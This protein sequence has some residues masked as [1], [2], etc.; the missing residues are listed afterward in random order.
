MT[1]PASA[2]RPV[3]RLASGGLV[4]AGLSLAVILASIPSNAQNAHGAVHF[5][6]TTASLEPDVNPNDTLAATSIWAKILGVE[7]GLWN[8]AEVRLYQDPS[9]MMPLIANGE[10]DFVALATDEFL[11]Y[12]N[13]LEV[14][15][16][17]TYIHNGSVELTWIILVPA[18]SPINSAADLKGKRLAVSRAGGGNIPMLWCNSWLAGNGFGTADSF[19][20][21]IR[22]VSKTS[23][24]IL[25]VFFNQ[26]EAALV[27]RSAFEAAVVLNPQL[28]RQLRVLASS[29]PIV[30][31]VIC[32]RRSL[33]QIMKEKTLQ[34]AVKLHETTSGLQSFTVFKMERIVA[35]QPS[36]LDGMRALLGKQLQEKP[37][38]SPV[39][40]AGLGGAKD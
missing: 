16:G 19:F 8:E 2:F 21:E 17:F 13:T 26:L 31:R 14:D 24:A 36:Y 5:G 38:V 6:I 32:F 20:S 23:Q 37:K 10:L 22:N 11:R 28:G 35:W 3:T 7:A 29:P 1:Q 30:P 34:R 40:K 18:A 4:L 39:S 33:S 15:P 9:A 25:P 12:Q 27:A